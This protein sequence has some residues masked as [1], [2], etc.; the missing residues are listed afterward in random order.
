MDSRR[1]DLL[2]HTAKHLSLLCACLLALAA[3]ACGGGGTDIEGTPT[4]P[5]ASPTA[6]IVQTPTDSGCP[7]ASDTCAFA[8]TI[9]RAVQIPDFSAVVSNARAREY[10]CPDPRPPGLGGPYPLCDGA[11]AGES[12][13]GYEIAY[14][15]S[16]GV[17]V[18]ARGLQEA[19]DGWA[20]SP[21][22]SASDAFG[23]GGNRLYTVGCTTGEPA[24]RDRFALV[25]SQLRS[26]VPTRIE[27]ILYFEQAQPG[28]PQLVWT[29]IGPLLEPGQ[30]H[31]ALSGGNTQEFL[32]L[33]SWPPLTTFF[34]IQP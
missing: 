31:D 25:F 23:D 6:A 32:T 13:S 21:D 10:S 8:E 20:R 3:Q 26:G 18:D 34:V 19:L 28:D 2:P 1:T 12:R 16:E 7:V 15:S 30:E 24:C 29:A 14:L 33:Q 5:A 11:T 9:D 17:V 22:S 27:L 4:S